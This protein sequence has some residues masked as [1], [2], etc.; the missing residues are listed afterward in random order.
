M[1]VIFIALLGIFFVF[2]IGYVSFLDREGS[3]WKT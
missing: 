1:D 3:Q 2:C